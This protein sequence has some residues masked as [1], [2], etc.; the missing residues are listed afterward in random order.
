MTWSLQ[1][2]K[3]RRLAPA[4]SLPNGAVKIFWSVTADATSDFGKADDAAGIKSVQQVGDFVSCG[5]R[6]RHAL[7]DRVP[8][9]AQPASQVYATLGLRGGREP[10]SW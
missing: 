5:C 3:G 4:S 2:L 7:R 8:K 9:S 10:C 1:G 6:P